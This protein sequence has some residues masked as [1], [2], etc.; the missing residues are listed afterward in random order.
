VD[1]A[2]AGGCSGDGGG[3][4]DGP[5]PWCGGRWSDERVEYENSERQSVGGRVGGDAKWYAL[6]GHRFEMRNRSSSSYFSRG[7]GDVGG[8]DVSKYGIV[9]Q[10][11]PSFRRHRVLWD[12]GDVEWRNLKYE[13]HSR[14]VRIVYMIGEVSDSNSDE[15][16]PEEQRK[17]AK[18]RHQ[19]QIHEKELA[20]RAER[21]HEQAMWAEIA[22][23]NAESKKLE[24]KINAASMCQR[25]QA[26]VARVEA[27]RPFWA[28]IAMGKWVPGVGRFG[29]MLEDAVFEEDEL[30][31]EEQDQQR[32]QNEQVMGEGGGSKDTV[33]GR[34]GDGGGGEGGS[35]REFADRM[36]KLVH[37]HG[38]KAAAQYLRDNYD[39]L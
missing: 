35:D 23:L 29:G 3:E 8:G 39:S 16:G 30:E 13:V 27:P 9:G 21:L 31:K 17:N 20:T 34:G 26:E 28:E 7:E 22:T 6:V 19:V 11:N 12:N 1:E 15:E 36:M 5:C 24:R 10:Y 38:V 14:Q 32:Q 33:G 37:K 2:M 25:A 18:R 4:E